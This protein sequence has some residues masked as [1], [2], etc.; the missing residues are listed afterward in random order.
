MLIRLLSFLGFKDSINKKTKIGLI[1]RLGLNDNVLFKWFTFP[2][3]Y[4]IILTDSIV[5][6]E[7]TMQ[8]ITNFQRRIS[9]YAWRIIRRLKKKFYSDEH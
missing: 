4:K 8:I 3:A 2:H 9:R 6:K 1:E 7:T 5:F